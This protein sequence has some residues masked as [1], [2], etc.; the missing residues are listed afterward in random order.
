[1]KDIYLKPGT[2]I[3]KSTTTGSEIAG[4]SLENF[5]VSVINNPTCCPKNFGG[6]SGFLK[7]AGDVNMT[8]TLTTVVDPSN[9]P[10]ILQLSSNETRSLVYYLLKQMFLLILILKTTQETIDLVLEGLP[11]TSK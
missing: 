6:G 11:L 10:S 8:S 7:L 1:M 9:N 2:Y 4:L 3:P 5:V